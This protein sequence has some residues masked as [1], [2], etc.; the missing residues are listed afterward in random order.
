MTT[1]SNY[2]NL[3]REALDHD[4]PIDNAD[5]KGPML[6]AILTYRGQGEIQT[7]KSAA[8]ILERYYFGE[9]SD[10]GVNV[11]EAETKEDPIDNFIDKIPSTDIDK[12]KK[13]IERDLTEAEDEM[14]EDN[15]DVDS[16]LNDDLED[17][18]EEAFMYE[19]DDDVSDISDIG[20]N[21]IIEKLIEEMETE[22]YESDDF[23][24]EGEDLFENRV[25]GDRGEGTKAVGT[26][27]SSPEKLIDEMM[28]EMMEEG[29]SPPNMG[30]EEEDALEDL[31][32]AF[33]IFQESLDDE[34][35]V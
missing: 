1:K 6:D 15:F 11:L 31:D 18:I 4:P 22:I 28:D 32:E 8:G 33:Q 5:V 30:V 29:I 34:L 14:D 24:E 26:I 9:K 35:M 10:N 27:D 19:S 23:M 20:E 7:H 21:A 25:E 2:M 13:Q 17:E 16:E 12:T 3:L